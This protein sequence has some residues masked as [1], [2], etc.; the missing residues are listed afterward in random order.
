MTGAHS[1]QN[2]KTDLPAFEPHCASNWRRNVRPRSYAQRVV[3]AKRSRGSLGSNQSLP[4]PTADV[5]ANLLSL[6]EVSMTVLSK[7]TDGSRLA[8][9]VAAIVATLACPAVATDDAPPCSTPAD[10]TLAGAEVDDEATIKL[11][12][13]TGSGPQSG[14]ISDRRMK[15][16]LQP[17]GVL[18]NGLQVYA[19]QFAWETKVRVGLIA[20]E[21][22]DRPDAKAAVLTLSNGLLGIDYASLGLRMAT[23]REWIADGPASLIASYRPKTAMEPEEQPIVLYNRTPLPTNP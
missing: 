8:A 15:Q 20:Q 17:V 21:L 3:I 22:A 9:A 2:R 4:C 11:R 10:C 6:G 13:K 12:A 7:I 1:L 18:A 16:D 14:L 23:E 19:F 5:G